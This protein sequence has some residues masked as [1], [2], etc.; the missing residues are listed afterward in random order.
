MSDSGQMYFVGKRQDFDDFSTSLSKRIYKSTGH[1][2]I[3]KSLEIFLQNLKSD[4]LIN[5]VIILL[6]FS[7]NFSFIIQGKSQ[8]FHWKNAQCTVLPFVVYHQKSNDDEITH[9]SFCFLSPNTKHNTSV[10]YTFISAL[11]PKSKCFITR[12]EQHLLLQ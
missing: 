8:G 5:E 12:T 9:K 6:D 4:L 11:M 10:V 2:Y 7:D 3:S 1:H